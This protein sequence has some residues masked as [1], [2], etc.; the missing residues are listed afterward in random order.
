MV[1]LKNEDILQLT[2]I[3][4]QGLKIDIFNVCI[5]DCLIVLNNDL[6]RL[7]TYFGEIYLFAW[8]EADDNDTKSA[9]TQLAYLNIKNSDKT[10]VLFFQFSKQTPNITFYF[11]C[12]P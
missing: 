1:S 11:I 3:P 7:Q 2:K 5:T 10:L 6:S 8:L 12:I 4:F 9:R